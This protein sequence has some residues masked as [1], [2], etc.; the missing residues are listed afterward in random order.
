MD[1]LS[2]RR[3]SAWRR[4][5]HG[6]R[7][8]AAVRRRSAAANARRPPLPRPPAG[9]AAQRGARLVVHNSR[10]S[11]TPWAATQ[12]G[13]G[14]GVGDKLLPLIRT[15]FDLIALPGR[16]ALGTLQSLPE[17]LEKM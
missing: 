1:A 9:A 17:V 13:A 14:G 2:M 16:V 4:G 8:P 6:G 10:Q 11:L 15:P 12:P 7:P 3:C 5:N